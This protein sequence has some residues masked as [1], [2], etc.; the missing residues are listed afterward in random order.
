MEQLTLLVN[1][2]IDGFGTGCLYALA[3]IGF[4]LLWWLAD[5]VHLAHGGVIIAAG[6]A[7][8][9]VLS[10]LGAPLWVALL[11]AILTA[12]VLGVLI[13]RLAYSRL[14][15]RGSGEMGMLTASLGLLI[16]LEYAVTMAFGPEGVQADPGATRAPLIPGYGVLLDTYTLLVVGVTAM[17]FAGLGFLMRFTQLGKNMRAVAENPSLAHSLGIKTLQVT[18]AASAVAAAAGA[19]AALVYLYNRG[20]TPHDAIHIVLMGAIVA[21]FGG[22]GS[23]AGALIAGLLIGVAESLM[24][25]FFDAG[26]REV[27]T[28]GLLYIL[29]LVRPQGLLGSQAR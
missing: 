5:I 19:P 10:K 23:I 8:Y 18:T 28:F 4:S 7:G 26:W 3:G 14:V 1:L 22:R 20:V 27:M 21:I 17:A 16:C 24:V 29:L 11:A 9:V 6:Y 25:W 2:L 13:D 15:R 12:V